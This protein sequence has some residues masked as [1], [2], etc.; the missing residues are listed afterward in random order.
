MT[1]QNTSTPPEPAADAELVE[2]AARALA[3]ADR[4]EICSDAQYRHSSYGGRARDV[5]AAIATTIMEDRDR[6]QAENKALRE[7]LTLAANRLARTVLEYE[8]NST[9]WFEMKEWAQEARAALT[10]SGDHD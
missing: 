2:L 8:V 10:G 9:G 5:I 1:E 3:Q 7:A 4:I 6:L